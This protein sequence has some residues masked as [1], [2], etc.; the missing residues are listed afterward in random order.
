MQPNR[1]P[2]LSKALLLG[3]PL[4]LFAAGCGGGSAR[5][6]QAGTQ[7]GKPS[8]LGVQ[9]G[10]L[11]DI[12]AYRR[13]DPSIGDRRARFNREA[14]RVARDVLID[15]TIESQQ[16]FDAGGEEIDSADYQFRPFDIHT[17][18]EELLI[19]WDDRGVEAS[20]FQDALNRAKNGLFEL[21]AA[22]RGQNPVSRP[23]PVVPRNAA[24][25][26]RFSDKI[27]VD[28][29][30]F[31]INPAAVQLLEF[32][33]DPKV[34]RPN[35]AFRSIPFRVLPQGDSIIL[36]TT[37]LGGEANGQF[38]SGLPASVD[39]V[40]ANIRI[41]IPSRGAVSSAFWVVPDQVL[42]LNGADSFGRESV[43]RDFRSGNLSDGR[44]GS[45][46][47]S[48][49]PMIV[50]DLD[51]GITAVDDATGTIT[52]NK[53]LHRV[54]VR[55]RFPFVEGVLDPA[56]FFPLGPAH[57]PTIVA[58]PSGDFLSQDVD[59]D[60]N[61]VLERVHLRAEILQNLDVGTVRDDPNFPGPGR[62]ADG[63][64]GENAPTVRIRLATTIGGYDSL[65][66]PVR[67]Q[68]DSTPEGKNAT[69]KARYYQEVRYTDGSATVSD[70]SA[71]HEFI[72]IDP[73]PPAMTG[74]N[75][76]P[77]GTRVD[78]HSSVAVSFSKPMDLDRVDP[79]LNFVLTNATMTDADFATLIF[80]PK[81]ASL[82][83]VPARLSD[84]T[85][86]GTNLQL[87][88][89]F[90]YC[91]FA[92]S[93]ETYWVHVLLGSGG[94]TDLAGNPVAIFGDTRNPTL[95]FSV[96][97]TLDPDAPANWVGWHNYRFEDIDEDGTATG[98]IDLFGQ[99]RIQGGRLSAADTVRFSRTADAQ[100]LGGISRTDRGE[101]WLPGSAT[102]PPGTPGNT[103]PFPPNA[104]YSPNAPGLNGMLY[105][106]PRM[107]DTV[108]PPNVPAVFLPPNSP[109][110]VGRIVE[111]H[112]PKGS[113]MMMRYLEDDFSLS[114]R[115]AS[116]FM[117]DVEQL[118][119]SEFNDENV[120]FDVFDRYTMALSHAD[121][122][123][124]ERYTITDV[125]P[126]PVPPN[127][128]T[129]DLRCTFVCASISSGLVPTFSANVLQ[130]TSQV[131][132]F[133]DKVYEINPNNAFRAPSG[134][135]YVA[136]PKFDRTYTWRDS[137]LVT[138]D[139]SGEVIGLGGA[140]NAR[141]QEPNND[142]TANIDSPWVTDQRYPAPD[143]FPGSVW[144]MD[145]HSNGPPNV[146][147]GD[148]FGGDFIGDRNRDHDPI[149][150][151]LLVDFKVFP[152]DARNGLALG[153][154]AF[155]VAMI[156]DPSNFLLGYAG[157][158]YNQ[159]SSIGCPARDPWVLI[160]THSTGGM[161]PVTQQPIYVDP[162]NEAIARGGFLKDA[163]LGDP[164]QGIFL[165]PPGDS[166]LHWAQADFVRKISSVTFGF[167]D[168][169]QSNK[170]DIGAVAGAGWSG[171]GNGN[172]FPDF[173][174]IPEIGIK[175]M[176]A[177][178][179]PPVNRQPAGTG[180]VLEFRG[181]KTFENATLYD[182]LV[183]NGDQVRRRGNLLNP[184]Y[185]C[186]AYRYSTPNSGSSYDQPRIAATGLTPYV[187]EDR[188]SLLRDP[189]TG[190]LPR[191]INLRLI[192]TNNTNVT[193]AV[194]PSLRS[195]T[196]VFRMDVPR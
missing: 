77:P 179:D 172:G 46:N 113:R 91:H 174:S 169:L 104:P 10:R 24:F 196:V 67:F 57:V 68:A 118:Y 115:Q 58:L 186:E 55:G 82:S 125:A 180:V 193:P 187:T 94:V 133:E 25:K 16:L 166:H 176:A 177:Q 150:L 69:L 44:F 182:Q 194:S 21:A 76:N 49:P 71:R 160:R 30:F 95:S 6:G 52:L 107:F 132:V 135:K 27:V 75:P 3:F 43:I 98:S 72:R 131:T 164:Q 86:D 189:V 63:T 47:D 7:N 192:M 26:L 39:N 124:D 54:P 147:N 15:P 56:T 151:P 79:T 141:A 152:D 106:Q 19:L 142:A 14:S 62:A 146:Q 144:V 31:R 112:Q 100:N 78:P 36:D 156:G 120:N 155:Q 181:A 90:G 37:I 53:R 123:S 42:E 48:E 103:A 190:L 12:Y 129:P 168:S 178:M 50:A 61:G 158:Y 34:V 84:L 1:N 5:T 171:L 119:W 143:Q 4:I 81:P 136:Y 173:T 157:G 64:Q 153:N 185:A 92:S 163:G 93:S 167:F 128:P 154:N 60:V 105:L 65:G 101:C 80:Q 11:V 162:A 20:R 51:M 145:I 29:T 45:L 134:A 99:Y 32:R 183:P 195:L 191:Y 89:P 130:G 22:Y 33:G 161:D 28:E 73:E 110:N 184:N 18:H 188:L 17:G 23:V 35:E 2:G 126:P 38:S 88:P 149:A 74:G 170:Q 165:A 97:F 102:P 66:R 122:R 108:F 116:Q 148:N 8:L 70:A 159:G 40:V 139:A 87:T 96:G 127:P 121:K 117:L 13:I 41:A 111:P 83:M 137:R 109:Q 114:Y 85:G 9:Y 138:I 140:I 59:V 175:D